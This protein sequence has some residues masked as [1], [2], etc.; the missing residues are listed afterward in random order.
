M[1]QLENLSPIDFEDLCRDIAQVE[2]GQRFSAFGPG[3]DGGIDGRHSLGT[4]TVI[5]Q[6]K[7]YEGSTFSALKKAARKEMENIIE[8]A[9]KR[10]LFFTSQ[11]LTPK[12]SDDL[13]RIFGNV[14]L[15]SDDVWGRED[16]EAAL[17]RNPEIEK[18]N[19]KLWMSSAAVIERI[20]QSGLE[21]F[22]QSTKSEILEDLKVYARNPSFEEAIDKLEKEKIL[23][24]SGPP[25]VGKT[26]LAKMVAYKYLNDGWRFYAISSLEDGFTKIED[27]RPTIFFFDDFLG[28]IELDRQSL[29]QRDTALST[30]VKRVRRSKNA[31]FVLTTRAHIF[32]E[33]RRLSDHVDDRRLQL[34]KYLLDVGAYT[35]KL[36]S[37]I[38]FNHLLVSGLSQ[39]HFVS[40]LKGDWLGKIVDHKNYNPRVIAS[41]SSDCLDNVEPEEYPQYIYSSLQ[42]PN[43]IWSKPFRTLNMKCQN[44]LV[45][46]FFGSQYGQG[47][48]I[49]RGNYLGLHR[50]VCLFYSQPIEP[51]DFEEA[52]RS[53]ESGFISIVGG[54]VTFVNPSV[55]DFLRSYLTNR[56]FLSLLPNAASRSDW[57]E[58]LWQHITDVFGTRDEENQFFALCFKGFAR[59]ISATPTYSRVEKNGSVSLH[60]DDL[61]LSERADLLFGWWE[62][63]HDDYFLEKMLNLIQSKSLDLV[64]WRDGPL[65]PELHWKAYNFIHDDHRL[66]SQLLLAIEDKI[67]SVF[68]QGVPSDELVSIIEKINEFLPHGESAHVDEAVDNAVCYEFTETR[69][70]ISDL[71]TESELAEHIDFLALLA[72]ITGHNSDHAKSVVQ[73]RILELEEVEPSEQSASIFPRRNHT[74]E[75]FT[76]DDL[77]S[78][79]S[80]LIKL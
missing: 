47:I 32:E 69:D 17:R 44:L 30:F 77:K 37:H 51:N 8:L 2:T 59:D 56:E 4:G 74:E 6:C 76:D 45:T 64:S 25:G 10:Y 42:N 73:D 1:S 43:L 50:A 12:R 61:P 27:E 49:L 20:L 35:R 9:P 29:L 55:R 70:A 41:V 39:Q 46:L 21:A 78:L 71:D 28:R 18:S 31:R 22:T 38:F 3:P 60:H 36:K 62:C 13:S 57:A 65:L 67:V 52:L 24:V 14:L 5:L 33:A 58:N 11:S 34:S 75:K 7:H 23:I 26:T 79:F 72:K 15:Q 66:K 48:E 80:N 54:T 63:T 53:L 16:I 68:D 40:I 19:V